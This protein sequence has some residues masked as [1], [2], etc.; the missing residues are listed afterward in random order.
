MLLAARDR[1]RETMCIMR[2]AG[3]RVDG[4][5]GYNVSTHVVRLR[6]SQRV[7]TANN[8]DQ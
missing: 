8:S 3:G 2:G 7:L 6:C 1:Q 4:D 5:G